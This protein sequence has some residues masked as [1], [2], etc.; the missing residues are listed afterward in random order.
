[1]PKSRSRKKAATQ[2]KQQ[3]Q[4]QEGGAGERA[5]QPSAV[6]FVPRWDDAA[7]ELLTARGW[8]SFRSVDM[9]EEGDGWQWMPSMLPMDLVGGG[10]PVPTSVFTVHTPGSSGFYAEPAS[11]DGIIGPE[12]TRHYATL[13]D[14]VADLDQLEAWR[15][16]ADE[17]ELP[18]QL[19][20]AADTPWEICELY[21]D[22]VIEPWELVSDLLHFPYVED[23]E[24]R[25]SPRSFRQVRRAHRLGL[26]PTDL[27]KA[28]VAGR[29]PQEPLT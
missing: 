10:E 13:E 3:R 11:A 6:D 22:G 14:L 16:P 21:A 19:T 15:V 18:E 26:I 5:P 24:D 20:F 17:Y 28:V 27:Y 8:I 12:G 1:M 7:E 4:L 29:T 23:P 25:M 9:D 2:K